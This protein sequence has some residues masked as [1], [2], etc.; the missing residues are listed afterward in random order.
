MRG[1]P[2][3]NS[4]GIQHTRIAIFTQVATSLLLNLLFSLLLARPAG[5]DFGGTAAVNVVPADGDPR[6]VELR[7]QTVDVT[8]GQDATGLWADTQAWFR[9]ANP[10]SKPVTVPVT[11]S[12]PPLPG[13]PTVL[14]ADLRILVNDKPLAV[15]PAA[16]TGLATQLALPARGQLSLRLGYRQSLPGL[17]NLIIFAYPLAASDQWANTPE[18]LRVTVRFSA[19]LAAGQLLG[20]APPAPKSDGQTYIWD[21]AA[22]RARQ[23]VWLAFIAPAWWEE[24]S[25]VR[26]A[27]ALPDAGAA[28]HIALGERYREL[29]AL[30]P[31][32]FQSETDFHARYYPAAVAELHSAIAAATTS[33]TPQEELAARAL[34][35]SLYR[36]QADRL[37]PE[38]GD[39]YLQLAAAEA[40][41]AL[42]RSPSTALRTSAADPALHD[43]AADAYR[44]LAD[45][46][47]A[48]G[49]T[50]AADTYL[51][52]LV[53]VEPVTET[54]PADQG[55][56]SDSLR[57]DV[58]T[59]LAGQAV[60]RGDLP[61]ARQI[62]SETFGAAAAW[63]P[64]AA[65]PVAA[66]AVV[67]VETGAGRR[68]ITLTLT[69]SAENLT[70]PAPPLLGWNYTAQER[71]ELS[72]ATPP[73]LTA[74]LRRQ[75]RGLGGEA[76][77][78]PDTI[79]AQ[80]AATLRA[81][82][83]VRVTSGDDWLALSFPFNTGADLAATQASLAAALPPTPELALLAATLAP[84]QLSWSVAETPFQQSWRYV[85]S[86]DLG[87]AWL[88]W[89]TLADRLEAA[90]LAPVEGSEAALRE[91]QRAFWAA[92]AAAWRGLAENSRVEYT[93]KLEAPGVVRRWQLSAGAARTLTAEGATWAVERLRWLAAWAGVLLLLVALSV[94][95]A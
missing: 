38:A 9:L 37:G 58:K 35:A 33:G 24:F 79:L 78:K 60:A 86:A 44:R 77:L 92:D 62:I 26:A 40:Q 52:R 5:A 28:T 8:I 95:Q 72:E 25:A 56:Q 1:Y 80:A 82:P 93:V 90:G 76:I 54:Q 70:P 11:L 32:S 88:T 61:A 85:E 17:A 34:L 46:A 19:P 81:V 53:A 43:L 3:T 55:Q 27:A 18:S 50:A 89:Q 51:A 15:A 83:G 36:Q 45:R 21:W 41:A 16:P 73:L 68:A 4:I 63:L 13:L 7:T 31:L 69:T 14:P 39:A 23:D 42:E 64:G 29:A 12:G 74:A 65:P 57:R 59:A 10:A 49:D 22:Q 87:L 94:W 91:V 71:G 48:Q 30:L 20:L 2:P 6:G 84:E 75:E 67:T 66:Q 47:R